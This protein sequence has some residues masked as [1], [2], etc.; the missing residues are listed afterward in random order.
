MAP[1]I[2][3]IL[4]TYTAYMRKKGEI[5]KKCKYQRKET[6]RNFLAFCFF[7]L[8]QNLTFS[9]LARILSSR[10]TGPSSAPEAHYFSPLARILSQPQTGPQLGHKQKSTLR[11]KR[12]GVLR[13]G[14][15]TWLSIVSHKTD[16]F[17]MY[18]REEVLGYIPKVHIRYLTLR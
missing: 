10:P 15:S 18:E 14:S 13:Q 16:V 11:V 6:L 2:V 3:D 12:N 1:R 4:T 9:S 5:P 7:V 17:D 8:L